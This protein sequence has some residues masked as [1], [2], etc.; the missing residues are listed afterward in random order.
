MIKLNDYR[1]ETFLVDP[2]GVTI[3]QNV[4]G[5]TVACVGLT[6]TNGERYDAYAGYGETAY[7]LRDKVEKAINEAKTSKIENLALLHYDFAEVSV[8]AHNLGEQGYRMVAMTNV[9]DLWFTAFTKG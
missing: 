3:V 8:T 5:G 2:L 9:G 4:S 6:M 1:N 7:E